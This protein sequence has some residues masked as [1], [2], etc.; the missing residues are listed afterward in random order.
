MIPQ[1]T[2]AKPHNRLFYTIQFGKDISVSMY[3]QATA[4]L[5]PPNFYTSNHQSLLKQNFGA[6]TYPHTK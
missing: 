5:I 4:P 1:D 3:Q 6:L 2:L